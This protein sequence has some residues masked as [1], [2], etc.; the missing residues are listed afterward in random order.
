MS[1]PVTLCVITLNEEDRLADCLRSAE[2]VDHTVVVDSESTDRTREIAEE[3]GAEVTVRQFS[4]RLV[5]Q[6]DHAVELAKTDW[7]LC[8]DSDERLSPELVESVKAALED[9]GETVA[10]SM[11]RRTWYLGRFIRHGGWYPDK[12]V[13]LFRRDRAK[14]GGVNPHDHVQVEPGAAVGHLEGDILHYSYRSVSDHLRQIDNFT[15]T[16]AQAWVEA[17]RKFRFFRLVLNP[18]GKFFRMY[19]L[20]AGFLDGAAGF[21]VAV[22]GSYYVFLK[23]LKFWELTR[24]NRG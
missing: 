9:P 20:K 1:E 10:F 7:V 11:N 14:W 23:Y 3:H 16:A 2:F 13:R 4:G 24:R 15:S 19:V 8:L 5:E 12:K 22:L 18:V 6:K 21:G 17:G